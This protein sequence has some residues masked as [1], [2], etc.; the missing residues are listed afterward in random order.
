MAVPKKKVSNS[1]KKMKRSH[2]ALPKNAY[3][4]DKQTG[5]LRRPHHMDLSTGIY[6]GRQ[7]L[8]KVK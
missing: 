7:V 6:R 4:E 1:R 8:D 2:M 3:V 5:N